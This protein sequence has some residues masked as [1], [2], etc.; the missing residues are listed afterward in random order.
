MLDYIFA[1]YLNI[2]PLRA[3]SPRGYKN[4]KRA[5]EWG[6][7]WGLIGR[8]LPYCSALFTLIMKFWNLSPVPTLISAPPVIRISRLVY[9]W[10]FIDFNFKPWLCYCFQ[11]SPYS[12]F[13]EH[14]FSFTTIMPLMYNNEHW[15]SVRHPLY[16]IIDIWCTFLHWYTFFRTSPRRYQV[17]R[18]LWL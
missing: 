13:C 4:L 15:A 7:S 16:W 9:N 6:A 2:V 3:P 10:P 5:I 12:L 11:K 18:E 14:E 8:G 17:P 1:H